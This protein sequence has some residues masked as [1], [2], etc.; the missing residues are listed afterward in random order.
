MARTTRQKDHSGTPK[1]FLLVLTYNGKD[2][3]LDC[4]ETV[5]KSDYPN[6][7]V[8]V[9]DN[10]GSDGTPV[11]VDEAW[12]D[13]VH[14]LRLFPNIKFSRANNAGIEYA[15]E[16]GADYVM[17]LND[18]TLIAEDMISEV[19]AAA[20]ADPGVGMAGPKIYY[21]KPEDQIWFAGGRIHLSRGTTEHIGI[22]E[23]D[24][25]QYD[26]A[27]EMDYIT[28]CALLVRRDVIEQIGVLDPMYKAYYED[29]DWSMRASRAGWK[30]LYVPSGRVWHR[31][32][33]A[34]GG[35]LTAY[36][37]WHKLRSGFIFLSR[38][39]RWYHFFTAPIF[40]IVELFR[41]LRL[42]SSGRLKNTWSDVS[43][44]D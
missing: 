13:R 42:A 5:M 27:A 3:V 11:A 39:G 29:T 20:E 38:Y 22:R 2:L 36:K 35:Q 16:H 41:V 24:E 34:T 44:G 26:T 28:G 21:H 37:I 9:I 19:V 4:L 6:L 10:G 23:R 43:S 12:G 7:H 32:S 30:L 31:I 1:V 25:G 17:L 33:A 18:D 14:V 15:L 40:Q 8:V